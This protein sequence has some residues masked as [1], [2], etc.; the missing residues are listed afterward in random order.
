MLEGIITLVSY[1]NLG[2]IF[3]QWE[4]MGFFTYLLPFLL[5]FALVFGVLSQLNLFGTNKGIQGIIA[6]VV[7]LMAVQST[8]VATFFSE[9]FPRAGMGIA[10]LLVVI[11]FLGLFLPKANWSNYLLLGA[12]GIILVLILINSTESVGWVSSYGFS[13]YADWLIPLII[14][15]GAIS[16]I[17]FPQRSH[18]TNVGPFLNQAHNYG[19]H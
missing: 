4:Q 18:E 14:L 8:I 7:G 10:V 9:I 3:S 2:N 13:E 1:G 16:L 11:I 17:V 19:H 15:F 6:L 12:G 5:I